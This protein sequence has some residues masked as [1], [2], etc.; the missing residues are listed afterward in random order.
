MKNYKSVNIYEPE[1]I[2]PSKDTDQFELVEGSGTPT[3]GASS[4]PFSASFSRLI[5]CP[6]GCL[7]DIYK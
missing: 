2:F 3:H 1:I 4:R 5:S 7:V 6:C